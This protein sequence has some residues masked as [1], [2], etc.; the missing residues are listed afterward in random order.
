MLGR[1]N[2]GF[3]PY[4]PYPFFS[5]VGTVAFARLLER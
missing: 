1:T 2:V 3:A 5:K 4:R